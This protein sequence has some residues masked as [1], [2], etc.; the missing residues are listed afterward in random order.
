MNDNLQRFPMN[1]QSKGPLTYSIFKPFEI[2]PKP[3]L[4]IASVELKFLLAA[5]CY[6][7]GNK[8]RNE[9]E[10]IKTSSSSRFL[11]LLLLN[12]TSSQYLKGRRRRDRQRDR[13]FTNNKIPTVAATVT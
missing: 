6:Y 1:M 4:K 11:L 3:T 2:V 13:H 8:K 7:G 9:R 10:E 5:K 12:F